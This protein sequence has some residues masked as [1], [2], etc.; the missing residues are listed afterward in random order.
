MGRIANVSFNSRL[1]LWGL[2]SILA[3]GF[4]ISVK[5]HISW[6]QHH[7]V[8][9][10]H[11]ATVRHYSCSLLEYNSLKAWVLRHSLYGKG[12][13]MGMEKKRQFL[14]YGNSCQK[15]K[16]TGWACWLTSLQRSVLAVVTQ[17]SSVEN[18]PPSKKWWPHICCCYQRWHVIHLR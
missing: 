1:L 18:A 2:C 7:H 13:R 4:H 8:R 15:R 3:I 17:K 6:L 10:A 12:G 14:S 5:I 16:V 9:C 11:S